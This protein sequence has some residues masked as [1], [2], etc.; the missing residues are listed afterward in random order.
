MHMKPL[1]DIVVIE[2]ENKEISDGG[3]VIPESEEMK[4]DIGRVVFAGPG[5]RTKDGKL[6]P[7]EVKPGDKVLFSTN[8]YQ[9]TR[10]NGKELVVTREPSI[11]AIL[12]E[13]RA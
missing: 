11:I 12:E 7:N 4:E 2:R 9:W 1:T 3:I 8:G 10:I 6:I 5:K 13:A